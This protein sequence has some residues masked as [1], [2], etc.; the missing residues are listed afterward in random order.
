MLY[1]IAAAEA[2]LMFTDQVISLY[3]G[4]IRDVDPLSYIFVVLLLCS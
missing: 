1:T 4:R 3:F 2:G